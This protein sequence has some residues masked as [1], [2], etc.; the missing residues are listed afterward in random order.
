MSPW[1]L[2]IVASSIGLPS[3]PISAT[4]GSISIENGFT[5]H[6]F[7]SSG[8]FSITAGS[9]WPIFIT[10]IHGGGGG[11]SG[12]VANFNWYS[13]QVFSGGGGRMN[14][15]TIF[16]YVSGETPT[17]SY[18]VTIG[19]G[20]S[21]G[22]NEYGTLGSMS[23]VS[24]IP[25]ASPIGSQVLNDYLSWPNAGVAAQ[26]YLNTGYSSSG[27]PGVDGL[28]FPSTIGD[29]Q[30]RNNSGIWSGKGPGSG[31]AGAAYARDGYAGYQSYASPTNPGLY[32]GN[33]GSAGSG[34]AQNGGNGG[35]NLGGS[36]GGGGAS[37]NG[38]QYGNFYSYL[39]TGGNG[40]SGQVI[41][42]YPNQL[43]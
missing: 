5:H 2:G 19:A 6:V 25:Q 35:T 15:A 32:G 42:S 18:A 7:N 12:R 22:G 13:P 27:S 29:Y 9:V 43:A 21:P 10:Y 36:G 40:G 24:Y 3:I 4:G 39:G 28:L 33:G 38:D 1:P 41:C 31:G 23:S 8:T 20:G 26:N 34:F 37:A 16:G 30:I 11:G 17:G 14:Q